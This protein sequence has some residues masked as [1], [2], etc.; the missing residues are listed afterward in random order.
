MDGLIARWMV[1]L[2]RY[3][4]GGFVRACPRPQDLYQNTSV[5]RWHL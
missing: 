2:L 5:R 3:G 1:I 4:G